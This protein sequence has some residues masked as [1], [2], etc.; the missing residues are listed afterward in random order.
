MEENNIQPS[1]C[2]YLTDMY[3]DFPAYPPPF[4]TL[5][6]STSKDETAPWGETIYI[7]RAALKE[8]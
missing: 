2:I 4:P 7:D 6:C 1:V 8:D 5:W 3:G